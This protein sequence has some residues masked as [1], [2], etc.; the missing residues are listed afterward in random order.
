M[1]SKKKTSTKRKPVPRHTRKYQFRDEHPMDQHV[2]S[3]LNYWKHGRQEITNLR[4]AIALYYAL[5][6]GQLS[7]LFDFFPEYKMRFSPDTAEALEQFMEIL[8]QQ[9]H[10]IPNGAGQFIK[11]ET[12][13]PLP[14]PPVVEVKQST[15]VSADTIADNVLSMF[16]D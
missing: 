14:A 1:A 12:P 9:Q 6:N 10:P 11:H 8:R 3:I 2:E 16:N 5:E 7:E 13:K 4:K 15:G